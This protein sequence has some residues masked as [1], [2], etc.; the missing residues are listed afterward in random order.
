MSINLFV[1]KVLRFTAFENE[2]IRDLKKRSTS[3]KFDT[4]TLGE[5]VVKSG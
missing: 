3:R 1:L 5:E 4:V 2:L